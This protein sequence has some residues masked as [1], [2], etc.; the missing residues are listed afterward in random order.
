[1]ARLGHW[2]QARQWL[3][4]RGVLQQALQGQGAQAMLP[5]LLALL[6]QRALLPLSL[7]QQALQHPRLHVSG[8][9]LHLHSYCDHHHLC[10][11][12]CCSVGQ[13]TRLLR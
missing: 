13:R 7:H 6:L 10:N 1:M 12:Q 5:L 3:A 11:E 8:L 4:Q 9:P 2:Q